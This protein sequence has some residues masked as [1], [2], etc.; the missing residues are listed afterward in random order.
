MT[1]QQLNSTMKTMSRIFL[2]ALTTVIALVSCGK[3]NPTGGDTPGGDTPGGNTEP[4]ATTRIIAV[5]FDTKDTRTTFDGTD[6]AGPHFEEDDVIR[7][8]KSDGS[9]YDD[10]PV[11]EKNGGYYI[12]V[13]AEFTGELKAVYPS[14]YAKMVYSDPLFYVPSLQ[15]GEYADANICTATI[16]EDDTSVTFYNQTAVIV[17]KVPESTKHLEVTSLGCISDG[18]RGDAYMPI[19]NESGKD[20]YSIIVTDAPVEVVIDQDKKEWMYF[21][22]ILTSDTS[23]NNVRLVDLNFDIT[24]GS[25]GDESYSMGGFPPMKVI[26]LPSVY[27]VYAACAQKGS[28]YILPENFLHEYVTIDGLKW[29]TSNVDATTNDLNGLYFSWG[30]TVGH[31]Y[32]IVNNTKTFDFGTSE[33]KGFSWMWY[34]HTASC[35]MNGTDVSE[36]HF[37]KYYNNDNVSYIDHV[38]FGGCKD[39]KEVL[40]LDDDAAFWNWGGSWRIPTVIEFDAIFKKTGEF[41]TNDNTGYE[42][43]DGISTVFFPANGKG[44]NK[45]LQEEGVFGYYWASS[46]NTNK[47]IN[48]CCAYFS[49]STVKTDESLPR[50]YGLSVRPVSGTYSGGSGGDEPDDDGGLTIDSYTPINMSTNI[51]L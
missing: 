25:T 14:K 51:S 35:T 22:S 6:Y 49:S 26:L 29:A 15:T 43:T 5:S 8:W 4:E 36:V 32:T 33:P 16:G 3:V 34:P 13:D 19:V 11:Y 18:H 21:V 30:D 23:E 2:A 27:D 10:C 37:N 47:W 40:D 17:V 1:S 46:L 20:L 38:I 48:G 24:Y 42:I 9:S 28:M 39:E 44:V 7:V 41:V 45:E 50:H 12:K 31:Q